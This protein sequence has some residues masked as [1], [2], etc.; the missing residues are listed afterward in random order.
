MQYS[1]SLLFSIV[2]LILHPLVVQRYIYAPNSTNVSRENTDK[3]YVIFPTNVLSEHSTQSTMIHRV[4]LFGSSDNLC[5]QLM[6]PYF[7]VCI[8]LILYLL[9]ILFRLS[10]QSNPCSYRTNTLTHTQ[11]TALR[12]KM[13]LQSIRLLLRVEL[14]RL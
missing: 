10:F 13:I 11:R 4:T 2:S 9:H 3:I 8:G 12:Q 6:L 5:V 1:S 7:S 14:M